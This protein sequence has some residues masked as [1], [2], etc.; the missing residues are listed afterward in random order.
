LRLKGL[1]GLHSLAAQDPFDPGSGLFRCSEE[2]RVTNVALAETGFQVPQPLVLRVV[3]RAVEAD[4]YGGELIVDK[5]KAALA[6]MAVNEHAHGL[7]RDVEGH[8]L[9]QL[10]ATVSCD[11]A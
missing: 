5:D 1:G 7:E 10:G 9:F 11:M 6:V 3:R 2:R 8:G 4:E